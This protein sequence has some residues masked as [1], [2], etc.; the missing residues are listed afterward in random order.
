MFFKKTLHLHNYNLS[1]FKNKNL[2]YLY[3]YNHNYY[4][5]IKISTKEIKFNLKNENTFELLYNKPQMFDISQKIVKFIKQFCI[6]EFSKIKFTGKGYKIKKNTT[7]NIQ[8]LFNRAHITNIWYKNITILKLKKYKMYVNY[9][10]FN[11]KILNTILSVRPVNIFTK[12]GL[13]S[14]RQILLKK[15]GKK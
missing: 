1:I 12:K 11:E 13:R 2:I 5:L 3:I 10:N 6:C 4:C 9:T 8:L 7:N 14:A 15:K